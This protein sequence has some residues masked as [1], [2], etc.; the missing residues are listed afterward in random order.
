L[1]RDETVKSPVGAGTSSGNIAE[2]AMVYALEGDGW[3]E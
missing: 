3:V 1:R 2:G